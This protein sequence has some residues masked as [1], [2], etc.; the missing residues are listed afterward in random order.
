MPLTDVEIKKLNTPVK[1]ENLNA[2]QIAADYILNYLL[3]VVSG[4]V[5]NFVLGVK[6]KGSHLVL[7]P[8]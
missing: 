6:K 1:T 5:G 4:G 2:L 7:I 3:V 8:M